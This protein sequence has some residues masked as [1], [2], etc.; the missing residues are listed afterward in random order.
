MDV[1]VFGDDETPYLPL[2]SF[3]TGNLVWIHTSWANQFN[4][5]GGIDANIVNAIANMSNINST[6][7]YE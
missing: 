3:L 7:I 5:G 4:N 2:N 1:Q 6:V